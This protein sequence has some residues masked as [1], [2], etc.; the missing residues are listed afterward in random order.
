MRYQSN[1]KMHM[2]F[3][4]T[5]I[6]GFLKPSLCF[7]EKFSLK[8]R[9]L[10]GFLLAYSIYEPCKFSKLLNVGRMFFNATNRRLKE[11]YF[12]TKIVLLSKITFEISQLIHCRVFF[13]PNSAIINRYQLF[14]VLL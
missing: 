5:S 6:Y 13:V 4:I 12:W 7:F 10:L 14:R 11:Q 1:S 9:D 3:N 8:L 2:I